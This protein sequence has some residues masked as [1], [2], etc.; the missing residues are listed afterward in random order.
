LRFF[1]NSR[2][3]FKMPE[4][5]ERKNEKERKK[6]KNILGAS[7]N[8]KNLLKRINFV[9]KEISQ[10]SPIFIRKC[11]GTTEEEASASANILIL[12]PRGTGKELVVREIYD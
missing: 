3:E 11:K 9:V 4:A 12:G 2:E 6:L 5:R 7:S 10:K 1:P 8:I